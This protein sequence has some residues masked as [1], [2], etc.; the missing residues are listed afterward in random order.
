MVS[1]RSLGVGAA[2]LFAASLLFVGAM[3]ARDAWVVRSLVDH[4]LEARGGEAL[5]A[6][7]SSLRLSGQMDVGRGLHVPYVLEQKKPDKVCLQFEFDGN[8]AIQC[9]DGQQGWKV[10][11]H[12]GSSA[13]EPMTAEE[14]REVS[15]FAD[16][17]SPLWDPARGV[18]VRRLGRA[19]VRDQQT[20]K[21]EV[22][23]SD[24][25]V[26]WV[27]VDPDTGL[28]V[29]IEATRTLAGRERRVDTYLSDWK[30][31]PEG[32]MVARRME[33]QTEG[34]PASHLLTVESVAVNPPLD[35]A[36]FTRPP[37]R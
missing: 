12:R 32:L 23:S 15:S 36:R 34:D 6:G 7:V 5:V 1:N 26:R 24:G 2:A 21:L 17:S 29:K 8:T 18:R 9:S 30:A 22:S 4:N 14:I 31:T 37:Q 16:P 28:E 35:D 11:P 27:Y 33:T 25:G 19:T 3:Y 20:E 10:V 13:P